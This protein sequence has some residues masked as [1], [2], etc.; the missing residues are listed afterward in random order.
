MFFFLFVIILF[1][2]EIVFAHNSEKKNNQASEEKNK[3]SESFIEPKNVAKNQ[4][5]QCNKGLVNVMSAINKDKD[6]KEFKKEKDSDNIVL[7]NDNNSLKNKKSNKEQKPKIEEKKKSDSDSSPE[8]TV[9]E[10]QQHSLLDLYKQEKKHEKELANIHKRKEIEKRKLTL[11]FIEKIISESNKSDN[12]NKK[13]VFAFV[14]GNSL[15]INNLFVSNSRTKTI[16]FKDN[17]SNNK[18]NN[19]TITKEVIENEDD[20]Y[21]ESFFD[22]EEEE[23]DENAEKMNYN[24]LKNKFKDDSIELKDMLFLIFLT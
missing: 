20:D 5:P 2:S 11:D 23:E 22:A 14:E 24:D 16:K 17:S 12:K 3:N 21:S 7:E 19:L 6:K 18:N 10:E 1:S 4:K 9:E 8:K 15:C 13:N